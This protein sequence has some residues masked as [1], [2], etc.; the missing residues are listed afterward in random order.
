MINE[1]EFDKNKWKT[2]NVKGVLLT[3]FF[4]TGSLAEHNID[5]FL[6]CYCL[7]ESQGV[8]TQLVLIYL[9]ISPI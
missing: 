4:V 2:N 7:V 1:K 6:F 5:G 3:F 9:L 8:E